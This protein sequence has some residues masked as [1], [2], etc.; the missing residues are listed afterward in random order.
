MNRWTLEPLFSV[1][2]IL[3]V[4]SGV[5]ALSAAAVGLNTALMAVAIIGLWAASAVVWS[6][7]RASR[8]SG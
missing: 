6:R 7:A 4:A 3:L 2:Y 5:V 8:R 1:V